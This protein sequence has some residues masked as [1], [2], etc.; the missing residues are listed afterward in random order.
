MTLPYR[1]ERTIVIEAP[2]EL[3]FSFFTD[4]ARWA[5]WWGTGSTI[6]AKAGGRVF[7]K[8][9][10]GNEASG[11]VLDVEPPERIVY[12]YGYA[13]GTPMPPGAS[14][15]TIRLEPHERGTLLH[16]VHEFPDTAS[17]EEHVQGWRY[18]LSL[19]GNLVANTLH[20]DAA[21]VTDRWFEAWNL[22]EDNVRLRALEAIAAPDIRFSDRY[23]LLVGIEDLS[24]GI[25]GFHRFFP[26]VIER[27][28]EPRHCQGMLLVDWQ[29]RRPDGQSLGAGTNVFRLRAD[30]RI[31]EVTGF[32]EERTK[33]AAGPG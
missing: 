26:F 24:S 11:E 19:F 14:R 25:A 27:R 3:V 21:A 17:R 28:G 6:E 12:T 32:W 2:R 30:G 23:S 5:S 33:D 29:A 20:A 31:A 8:H 4:S 10:G 7:I 22:S 1:V 9:P 15:A 18:Q 13:S 16:L